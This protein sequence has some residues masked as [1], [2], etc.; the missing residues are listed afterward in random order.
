MEKTY[1]YPPLLPLQSEVLADLH[2]GNYN[3]VLF[4][5]PRGN[6]KTWLAARAV[7]D[8]IW[9]K[10]PH[11]QRGKEC[12]I[13]AGSL[14]QAGLIMAE[15]TWMDRV[16]NRNQNKIYSFA[17][18]RNSMTITHKEHRT[19]SRVI[20]SKATTALGLGANHSMIVADEPGA[21]DARSGDLMRQALIGALGKHGS[22]LKIFWCG[23]VSPGIGGWW[24]SKVADK[25]DDRCKR[26]VYA[27]TDS[28]K[29]RHKK[30][31]KAMNPILAQFEDSFEHVMW[32]HEQAKKDPQK[33]IDFKN[34]RLNMNLGVS[35]ELLL[36]PDQIHALVKRQAPERESSFVLAV[37]MGNNV[38]WSAA[39]AIWD[40]GRVE[41]F[42]ICPGNPNIAERERS[43]GKPVG[44]YQALVDAGLLHVL[45]G[46]HAVD[47]KELVDLVKSKW[48][49][50]DYVVCDRFK[51]T[52]MKD[53]CGSWRV[54]FRVNQWS[55]STFDI[56]A[57]RRMCVEGP[58]AV[59]QECWPLILMSLE[60]SRTRNDPNQPKYL[61]YAK[62]DQ[63]NSGR[64]DVAITLSMAA[65][66]FEREGGQFD[67]SQFIFV[68]S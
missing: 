6:G 56:E 23:T 49:D 65:G 35:S 58:I 11:Y 66:L 64:D 62:K 16:R 18:S 44:A 29:W 41:S 10:S 45:D 34:W 25:S 17:N 61:K 63:S 50:P 36:T 68:P 42:A 28:S 9:E 20:S 24:A 2:S 8:V 30:T 51:Q 27:L 59:A 39:T 4:S 43:D 21:W 57:L 14:E 54:E 15:L 12:I 40:N 3:E 53:H 5:A 22:T 48:G 33:E 55:D 38:S 47:V 37:D 46:R 7:A 19:R 1:D 26:Y 60:D 52:Q 67:V 31:V 13:V 32:D